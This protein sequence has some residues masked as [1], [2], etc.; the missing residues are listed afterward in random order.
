MPTRDELKALIDQ[1]PDE[2]LEM[3]RINLESIQHPPI[4]NPKVEQIM[5]RSE[6]FQ[7]QLPERLKQLQAG[8]RPETI[9]G[10]GMA[11]GF[12]SGPGM[13]GGQGQHAYSWWEDITYVTH[14]MM[15][16]AGRELDIVERLQFTEDETKL[17]YEQEIYAEG[18]TIKRKEEFPIAKAEAQS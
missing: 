8:C 5:R 12:G 1:L 15:L 4:P 11:G 2:K 18:R 7:K 6:E 3:V 16:H 9:R 17:I 14:R 13:R 10:F